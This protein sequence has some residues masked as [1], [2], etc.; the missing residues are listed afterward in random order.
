VYEALSYLMACRKSQQQQQQQQ[1]RALQHQPRTLQQQQQRPRALPSGLPW[2]R[3]QRP[4]A[5]LR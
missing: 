2:T 3:P 4:A 1:Q 5:L